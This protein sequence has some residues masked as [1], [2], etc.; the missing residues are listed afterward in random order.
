MLDENERA[1]DFK[2]AKA[3][4]EDEENEETCE[5]VDLCKRS[6]V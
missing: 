3:I 5:I 2:K 4:E 1:T 6:D